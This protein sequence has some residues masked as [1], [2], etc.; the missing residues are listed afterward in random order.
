MKIV[1]TVARI[2]LGVMFTVFGLN[3]FLHFIPSPAFPPGYLL[4]FLTAVGG[5][6]YYVLI[7][8]VQL[9]CG[10]MLLTGQYV[11]LAIVALGAVLANILTFHATMNPQGFPPAIVALILW[12]LTAWP[13]RAQFA[14]IFARKANV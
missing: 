1:S 12:F 7:F 8:G 3:G 13:I 14:P 2:L 9:I 10:I 4:D 6:G 5:S 11:P